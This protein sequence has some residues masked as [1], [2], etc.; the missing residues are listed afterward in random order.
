MSLEVALHPLF[1]KDI[2]G[3][4]T[5][6]TLVAVVPENEHEKSWCVVESEKL[7]Q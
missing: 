3:V 7:C 1:L 6:P 2:S 5:A 4:E